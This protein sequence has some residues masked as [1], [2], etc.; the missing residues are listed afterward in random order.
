MRPDLHFS[1]G[2]F[3]DQRRHFSETGVLRRAQ[4][5]GRDGRVQIRSAKLRRALERTVLVQHHARR[6]QC[7]PGQ[8]VGEAGQQPNRR[9]PSNHRL[10]L[11]GIVWIARTGAP[12][13]DLP[14]EFDKWSSVY[15]QFRRWTLVGLWEHIL[16][17][18]NHAEIT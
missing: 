11:D 3:P 10:F 2:L 1:T 18:L 17:A 15:R 5:F 9:K 14:E 16:D 13:R 8:K 7:R 4:P 6:D 12:W